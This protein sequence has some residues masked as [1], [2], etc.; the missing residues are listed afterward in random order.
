MELL[1]GRTL[2]EELQ[3]GR[4]YPPEEALPIVTQLAEGLQAAH[5]AGVVHR[6]LKPG[7]VILV[8]GSSEPGAKDEPPRAVI[9]DFGLAVSDSRPASPAAT[10]SSGR[11]TT[12]R[13]NSRSRTP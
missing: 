13:P 3:S 1:N 6:D 10:S 5:D 2:A 11:P 9:T 8:P 12:W 4:R 7:N